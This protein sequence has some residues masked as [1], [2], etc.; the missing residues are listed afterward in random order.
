[1]LVIF[2]SLGSSLVM[3]EQSKKFWGSFVVFT[4]TDLCNFVVFTNTDL[5]RKE[6]NMAVASMMTCKIGLV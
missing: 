5:L 1:M 3:L 2:L 4:N 6:T